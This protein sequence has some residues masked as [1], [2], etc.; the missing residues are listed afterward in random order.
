MDTIAVGPELTFRPWGPKSPPLAAALV[1]YGKGKGLNATLLEGNKSD[2]EPFGE[3]AIPAAWFE[4]MMPGGQ[5]DPAMHTSS[6][7]MDHVFVNLV[8]ESVDVVK[9]YLMTLDRQACQA[10]STA[11]RAPATAP[12]GTK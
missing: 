4:R 2:N 10:M 12:S 7:T 9:G 11:A 1:A 8:A 6:D 3:A 5:N